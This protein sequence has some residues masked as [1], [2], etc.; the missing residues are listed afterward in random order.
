LIE[1]YWQERPIR[2][3][4]RRLCFI[5]N[6]SGETWNK[7]DQ[8]KQWND[9]DRDAYTRGIIDNPIRVGKL[10]EV[11]CGVLLKKEPDFTFKKGGDK[12]DFSIC[13]LSVD[14][15]TTTKFDMCLLTVINT[16]GIEMPWRDKDIFIVG[17]VDE[18]KTQQISC[19]QLVGYFYSED[20]AGLP[21]V[22]SSRAAHKNKELRFIS[23]RPLTELINLLRNCGADVI[24]P[25]QGETR[26]LKKTTES[27]AVQWR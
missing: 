17:R 19:V 4:N 22:D 10:G 6:I 16:Q 12:N 9:R 13:G 11:A 5:A 2:G 23:S 7:C 20:V 26:D 15:K 3:G 8:F 21:I 25:E 14:V 18:Y 1:W 27:M 24:G